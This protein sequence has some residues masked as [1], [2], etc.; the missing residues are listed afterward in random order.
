ME[1]ETIFGRR[2]FVRH[3]FQP[4]EMAASSQWIS[5]AGNIVNIERIESERI[6][7]SWKEDGEMKT[8]NK[9]SFSFQC[10]YSLIID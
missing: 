1:T 5:A 9:D 4:E 6:Y 10:R 7:Y 2:V 3:F 8:H